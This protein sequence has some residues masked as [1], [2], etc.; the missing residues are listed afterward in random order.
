MS[1]NSSLFAQLLQLVPQPALRRIVR[2]EGGERCAKGF[3]CRMQLVAMLY[4]Q[5]AQAR[6]LAEICD[7][8]RLTCGKLNHLG[9]TNAPAKS[10]LAYA[11]EHRAAKIYERLF[12]A[13]LQQ[14]Q[15]WRPGKKRRFR[16]KQ[17]LLTLDSTT[18]ELC[19]QLFPWAHY[20]QRKGAAKVHLVLD[21]DGYLPTFAVITDGKVADVTV[22]RQLTFPKGSIVVMDRGYSDYTLFHTWT[23]QGVFFVTRLKDNAITQVE[24]VR[25]RP[26]RQAIVSDEIITL[27]SDY[28]QARCPIRLR[29]IV[30]RDTTG[31]EIVLLTNHLTLG[32]TTVSAIYRERWQIEI[33]F[34]TIKQGL[35]IKTFVGTS[36]NALAV[37]IWTALLAV[38]LL[39]I[40][41]F[42]STFGWHLSRL[43]ALLRVNLFTYRDLWEWLNDPFQTPPLGP[44]EQLTI[45]F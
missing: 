22:A 34:R 11:N 27:S 43:V 1:A 28:A 5:L 29:R 20:Q 30:V 13:T 18:L 33:F 39:A 7:G 25:Q 38:L 24:Q 26:H 10:S 6:S 35:R 2:E 42:R 44:P 45:T 15:A 32:A 16:F 40:C 21:N 31:E 8:L 36:A 14:A 37:Q 3:T 17:Q 9:L 12:Y 19:A 4:L 23:K 41:S